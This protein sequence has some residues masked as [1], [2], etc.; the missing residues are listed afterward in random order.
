MHNSNIILINI[1]DQTLFL[2]RLSADTLLFL[3]GKANQCHS[4]FSTFDSHVPLSFKK[5]L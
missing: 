5:E 2:I 1:F 4:K 3:R